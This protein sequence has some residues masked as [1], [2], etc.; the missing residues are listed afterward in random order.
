METVH[1]WSLTET[2]REQYRVAT[3]NPVEHDVRPYFEPIDRINA[4]D[5]G[6]MSDAD[7]R[8]EARSVRRRAADGAT[9]D[10]LM[11]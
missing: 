6:R 3:G 2:V 8:T 5:T 7:L 1:A 10:A 11:P 9:L 4:I